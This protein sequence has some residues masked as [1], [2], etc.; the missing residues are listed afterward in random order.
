MVTTELNNKNM[1]L[2]MGP[3]ENNDKIREAEVKV[4]AE[5]GKPQTQHQWKNPSF[6]LWPKFVG[7]CGSLT[8]QK[9]SGNWPDNFKD[10]LD[11][12]VI[13]AGFNY[14]RGMGMTLKA[15]KED[16]IP[17]MEDPEDN[18]AKYTKYVWQLE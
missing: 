12:I 16:V 7:E 8:G 6:M 4:K 9:F 11:N 13:Y 1:E 2:K 14:G 3:P 17:H 5:S 10:T 18:V 15:W